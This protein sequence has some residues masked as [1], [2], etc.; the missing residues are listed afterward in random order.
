VCQRRSFI[1]V[2]DLNPSREF[3]LASGEPVTIPGVRNTVE[4]DLYIILASWEQI[5]AGSATFK[6]YLNP[7]INWL[8]TGGLVFILGTLVAAWPSQAEK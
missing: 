5:S 7:L 2:G 8:W 4:D 3:Y 6:I 1:Y